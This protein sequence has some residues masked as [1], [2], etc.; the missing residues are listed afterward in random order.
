[1]SRPTVLR[2]AASLAAFVFLASS[3]HAQMHL[4]KPAPWSPD[5][6]VKAV[7]TGGSAKLTPD[8][9]V[10]ASIPRIWLTRA[11]RSLW[12]QTS[13]YEEMMRYCRSLEAGSRWVKLETIGRTGQ[14]RDL[15]MLILSKDRAFTPEAA[16]ATGKP[17]VLIQN[18]IHA[19]EI[20][21]KDASLMLL[22][23]LAALHRKDALLDSVIV[24][25]VPLFS[26][27]AAER[28]SHWNRI[29]QNGPDEMGWRHTPIGLNLNRD[30]MKLDAPEMRA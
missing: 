18:G 24:L 3:V 12:K 30:Y 4:T 16:R 11:E 2:A 28:R 29:N 27:D 9:A 22:R 7:L 5:S 25:V 20:E 23:D 19:G 13:D 17:I 26:T 1:M 10:D 8:P 14:G 15:P 21:G 6:A